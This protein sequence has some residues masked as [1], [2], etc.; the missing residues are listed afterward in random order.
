VRGRKVHIGQD[1]VLG[2]VH[3][4]G[5]LWVRGPR[6]I[7]YHCPCGV[8]FL[9]LR[10]AKKRS[11]DRRGTTAI[12]TMTEAPPDGAFGPLA[13]VGEAGLWT[14]PWPSTRTKRVLGAKLT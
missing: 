13:A 9:A 3:G 8:V 7:G 14:W 1:L 5:E 6:W 4:L 2:L 10:A 12:P 11:R